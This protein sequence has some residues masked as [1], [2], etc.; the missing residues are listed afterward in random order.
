[1]TELRSDETDVAVFQN[2]ANPGKTAEVPRSVVEDV[3][4]ESFPA[5]CQENELS[6]FEAAFNAAIDVKSD[7]G[8]DAF[9]FGAANSEQM[10]N[11]PPPLPR[12]HPPEDSAV[13]DNLPDDD[14]EPDL[15]TYEPEKPKMDFRVADEDLLMEKQAILIE[16]DHLRSQGVSITREFSM[17]DTL[18]SMQFEVRRHLSHMDETRMVGMLT[19]M[20]KMG[21]TGLEM[22]SKRYGV[23]DLDGY[24]AE[25]TSDMSRFTPS[26]TRMYRKYYR[27]TVWSPEAELGFAIVSSIAMFHFRKKFYGNMGG[28]DS[29]GLPSAGGNPFGFAMPGMQSGGPSSFSEETPPPQF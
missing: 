21:F 12:A 11:S 3:E 19:D 23:L 14:G 27:K 16:I 6:A 28:S 22:A 25:I 20:M 18:E 8:S 13:P 7:L 26:M 24:S 29:S 5:E 2:M 4:Q 1:M 10:P 17:K 15:F 9:D